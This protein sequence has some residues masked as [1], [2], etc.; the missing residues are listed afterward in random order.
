MKRKEL[1]RPSA[2][3]RERR[4]TKKGGTASRWVTIRPKGNVQESQKKKKSQEN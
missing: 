4:G 1:E 3:K 2:K